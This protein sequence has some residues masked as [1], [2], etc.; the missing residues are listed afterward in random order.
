MQKQTFYDFRLAVVNDWCWCWGCQGPGRPACTII[1]G[2]YMSAPLE[3]AKGQYKLTTDSKPAAGREQPTVPVDSAYCTS[4]N[5]LLG[6]HWRTVYHQSKIHSYLSLLLDFCCTMY[7]SRSLGILALEWSQ[8][9][10]EQSTC[11]PPVP[12]LRMCG[13]SAYVSGNYNMN[14][15]W[16]ANSDVLS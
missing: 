13:Y 5:A 11:H 14:T 3:W 2:I 12:R 10:V 15:L 6:W 1:L 4:F 8:H 7:K 16:E 9:C